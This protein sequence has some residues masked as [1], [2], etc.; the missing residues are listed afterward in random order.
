MPTY[1]Y[2]CT[3]CGHRF[4]RLQ[5]ITDDPIKT[6]PKC[7]RRVKRLIGAGLGIIFKG[8]GFY[9]TDYKSPSGGASN[10]KSHDASEKSEKKESTEKSST[11]KT[12]SKDSSKTETGKKGS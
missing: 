12:S 11:E 8:S 7:G 2:E 9:S 1:E 4:E 5:K 3:S 6:C 10:G